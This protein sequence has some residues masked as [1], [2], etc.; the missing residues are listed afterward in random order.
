MRLVDLII[1]DDE[2]SL[3][4]VVPLLGATFGP[5]HTIVL[6]LSDLK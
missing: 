3:E 6:T 4:N 2:M 5:I 1:A